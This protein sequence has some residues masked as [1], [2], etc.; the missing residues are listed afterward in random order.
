M[1]LPPLIHVHM[2]CEKATAPY[3][4]YAWETMRLLANSPDRLRL[5]I[6]SIGSTAGERLSDLPN[7]GYVV[8]RTLRAEKEL[9]GSWGHACCIMHALSSAC[10][11]D[12]HVICD[13]DTVVV[14]R[15]WDDYLRRRIVI[16]GM[17]F[18][19]T[20]Y[21]DVGGFSSGTSAVQTYKRA[22][23]FT[24][25]AFNPKH[26]WRDLDVLPDKEKQIAI[27]DERLSRLYGLPIGHSVFGEAGW[28]VPQF[29][30]DNGILCD[31]WEHVKPT[32]KAVVLEGLAD[33]NEEFH[34]QGTPFVVHQRGSLRHVFRED[35]M[36][37]RF[38]DTCDAWRAAE[39]LR[40]ARWTWDVEDGL[41]K[42]CTAALA[43]EG[44]HRPKQ[45][46]YER[47]L[48]AA[49]APVIQA[50][51]AIPRVV[52]GPSAATVLTGGTITIS[53]WL[54]ATLDGSVVWS[55]HEANVPSAVNVS[56]GWQEACRHLRLEGTVKDVVVALPLAPH[57]PHTVIVR[58]LTAGPATFM[59]TDGARAATVPA[60]G[61]Q[62]LVI[63][64]DGVSP[65]R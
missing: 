4:R 57:R 62:L 41:T 51:V 13:S 24:F 50:P 6:H 1:N 28:Q 45:S 14:A 34:A 33:Y 22:P 27:T 32:G 37:R 43:I 55:R 49:Q 16:D 8:T 21:E 42:R 64:V 40:P 60:D 17:G 63:D 26:D 48:E 59:T 10:D 18:I 20:T 12:V 46:V 30:S 11:G 65:V 56:F 58:N 61:C 38:Y 35:K 7:S 52:T 47:M 5:T 54:K 15:G 31:G 9:A 25:A 44:V 29:V 2:P 3:A 19:G 36:S 23:T 53:G 39:S